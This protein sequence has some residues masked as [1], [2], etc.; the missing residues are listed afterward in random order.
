MCGKHS[1]YLDR[2][3]DGAR[4]PASRGSNFLGVRPADDGTLVSALVAQKSTCN[5]LFQKVRSVKLPWPS[6]CVAA[7]HDAAL[8]WP[9][10]MI[11][12]LEPGLKKELVD[13]WSRE[14][15]PAL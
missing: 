11:V 3:P 12:H 5:F 9:S 8:A 1:E 14:V 4:G 15:E 10:I 7:H 6:S 2:Y 13:A